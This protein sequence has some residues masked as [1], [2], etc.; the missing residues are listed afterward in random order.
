MKLAASTNDQLFWMIEITY[1]E[2]TALQHKDILGVPRFWS[3]NQDGALFVWPKPMS[4]VSIY[5]LEE[6]GYVT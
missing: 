3:Q 6:Q 5:R 1:E 4:G 2:F